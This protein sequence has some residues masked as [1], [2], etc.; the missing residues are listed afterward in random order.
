M[1][2]TGYDDEA[3]CIGA[4]SFTRRWRFKL[5]VLAVF[6]ASMA[7]VPVLVWLFL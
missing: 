4:R 5:M 1:P 2:G 3:E 6:V 7:V